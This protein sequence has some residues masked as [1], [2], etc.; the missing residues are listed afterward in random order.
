MIDELNHHSQRRS[1][2][3]YITDDEGKRGASK[4]F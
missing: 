4:Q 2:R 3:V 1:R